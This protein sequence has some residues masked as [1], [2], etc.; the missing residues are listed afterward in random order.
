MAVE[1][2]CRARARQ[3]SA[4]ARPMRAP[5]PRARS[6]RATDSS[7]SAR[8]A[9]KASDGKRALRS[10]SSAAGPATSSPMRAALRAS[11]AATSGSEATSGGPGDP[12]SSM[13]AAL[14]ADTDSKVLLRSMRLGELDVEGV[15]QGQH[16][17]DAGVR[18]HPGLEEV[19]VVAEGRRR[20]RRAWRTRPTRYESSRRSPW[21]RSVP[22]RR[23]GLVLG[24]R[25][26]RA[27]RGAT[28]S[29]PSSPV[30]AAQQ[31]L[32]S[33]NSAK[34]PASTGADGA[35]I[36]EE[37]HR[38]APSTRSRSRLARKVN[39]LRDFLGP[40]PVCARGS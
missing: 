19:G 25:A 39:R 23:P 17:V 34:G 18:G 29:T 16:H 36:P 6:G 35:H 5:S 3:A 31:L 40:T 13:S 22:C 10:T 33:V 12:T 27:L 15:L 7:C 28:T 32:S 26:R 2:Q 37:F 9:S 1:A 38:T 30:R 24:V 4:T 20:R 21:S 8:R 11:S 14:M